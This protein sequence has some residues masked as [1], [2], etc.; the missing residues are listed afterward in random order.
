MCSFAHL[1]NN[2]FQ[3]SG[4]VN[5][6]NIMALRRQFDDIYGVTFEVIK[7]GRP[8]RVPSATLDLSALEADGSAVLTLLVYVRRVMARSGQSVEFVHPGQ[9]LK[10]VASLAG[11]GDILFR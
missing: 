6:T 1:G 4:T 2:H 5:L 7:A 3:I 10:K 9:N 11:L 8:G